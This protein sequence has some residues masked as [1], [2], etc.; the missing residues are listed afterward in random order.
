MILFRWT[1]CQEGAARSFLQDQRGRIFLPS[2]YSTLP[3]ISHL[4]DVNVRIW[5]ANID[6]THMLW[7]TP[8]RICSPSSTF[9]L[10]QS[11][12]P[13]KQ[14]FRTRIRRG[15]LCESP[16]FHDVLKGPLWTHHSPH[17]GGA[18]GL[19]SVGA[20]GVETLAVCVDARRGELFVAA[21]R[22]WR[23]AHTSDQTPV[24]YTHLTLPTILRV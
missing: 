4:L 12:L 13:Q 14:V 23:G 5:G 10:N 6:G 22:R 24:S 8:L 18:T 16:R 20:Q 11:L 3:R 21:Y 1:G 7:V 9:R 19:G 2:P 15:D 17:A